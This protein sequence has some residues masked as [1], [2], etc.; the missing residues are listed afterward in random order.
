VADAELGM[1]D[2]EGRLTAEAYCPLSVE[3]RILIVYTF[4]R[5]FIIG[6]F[7][8]GDGPEIDSGFEIT[9]RHCDDG[10]AFLSY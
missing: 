2:A 9:N 4:V 10:K 8:C 1:R 3:S 5:V 6:G 7:R